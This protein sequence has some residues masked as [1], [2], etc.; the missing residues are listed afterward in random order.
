MQRNY[1]FG[2]LFYK[3]KGVSN[4][5]LPPLPHRILRKNSPLMSVRN[6][7]QNRGPVAVG[8][9]HGSLYGRSLMIPGLTP[10]RRQ[11]NLG[12]RYDTAAYNSPCDLA[13]KT[14]QGQSGSLSRIL[15]LQIARPQENGPFMIVYAPV[16][17]PNQTKYLND[18]LK[19][20]ISNLAP[21]NMPPL[22][23]RQNAFNHTTGPVN[24]D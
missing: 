5:S 13:F 15:L 17:T 1:E 11:P 24:W 12:E 8:R 7:I 19:Y 23:A 20:E 21:P 22:L 6:P 3:R 4:D 14:I 16:G 18:V 2:A 9:S 10:T